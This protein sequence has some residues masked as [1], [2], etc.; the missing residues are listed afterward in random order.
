MKYDEV[1]LFVTDAAPYMVKAGIT[2]QNLYTKII[3]V[4]CLAHGLR[5]V[6]EGIRNQYKNVDQLISNVK[7]L[8]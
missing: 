2:I 8:F 7:N 6:A 5:R 3:H 4:T 1:L